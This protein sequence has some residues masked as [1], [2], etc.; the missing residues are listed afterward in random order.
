MKYNA[1]KDVWE[2][3]NAGLGEQRFRVRLVGCD[4]DE[5]DFKVY[6]VWGEGL[7]LQA[8]YRVMI[9]EAAKAFSE[10]QKAVERSGK[11]DRDGRKAER[12]AV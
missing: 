7:T 2:K 4:E 10:S 1:A 5:T 11:E 12:W 8:A 6:G 3:C 9:R